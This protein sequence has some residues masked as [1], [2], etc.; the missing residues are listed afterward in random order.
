TVAAG[1]TARLNIVLDV[2]SKN[3]V[4]IVT[5]ERAHGEAEAINEEK[6]ADNILYVLPSEI[7][8][9]LPNANIADAVGRLPGVTLE[10]DQG[11]RKYAQIR[12]TDRCVANL[13]LDGVEVPSPE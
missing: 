2:A 3:D 10:R 1:Q 5:A 7:I 13:T 12:G 8:T 9:S 6:V 11:E 4:V